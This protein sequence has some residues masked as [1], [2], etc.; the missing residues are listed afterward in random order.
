MAQ[1]LHDNTLLAQLPAAEL[2]A[3]ASRLELLDVQVRDGVYRP[4][5]PIEHV[6]FPLSS[7]FSMVAW[8]PDEQLGV[9]VGTIG[10][11]GFVG[12]PLFLGSPVSP[13]AAFCQVAGRA[14]RLSAAELHEFLG[15]DGRLHRLLHR[16]TQTTMVQLAQNVA[17]NRTHNTEQRTARWLLTTADRVRGDRFLLTQDFLA[18]MLGVRRSTVSEVAGKL[19][20]DGLIEYSRGNMHLL[21]RPRL[22]ELACPCY[23]VLKAEFD[24][25]AAES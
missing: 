21:N 7:V 16:F 2:D 17:C 23:G 1:E 5:R 20:A 14:A 4:R 6:Y 19:Q 8:E 3:L 11:E 12:L 22:T 10:Y 9:E 25:L 15:Q 24:A 18:Q 13:H